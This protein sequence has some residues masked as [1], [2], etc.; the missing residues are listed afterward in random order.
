MSSV[1]VRTDANGRIL[2]KSGKTYQDLAET[3]SSPSD[4][5]SSYG[6]IATHSDSTV[7][8]SLS[9]TENGDVIAVHLVAGQTYA[10][11]YRGTPVDGIEDPYLVLYNSAGAYVTEDDD[12]GAGRGSMITYTATVTGNHYLLATS[13]YTLDT[14]NPTL[15]TGNYTLDVWA[16]NL[17]HDVPGTFAGAVSI[18][19]GT[20][21]GFLETP[22]DTDMYRIDMTA[23]MVYSFGY[24]GGISSSGDWDDEPG[25][26]IGYLELY[27]AGGNLITEAVNYET[28]LSFFAEEN[29][30]YYLRASGYDPAMTGGYTLDLAELNPAD[31]DPLESLNWDSAANVPFVNVAGT[32]TAYVYFAAAGENFGETQGDS[33]AA[34]VSLGWTNYEMQQVMLA[35]EEYEHI[36]GVDY[37]V[38]TDV[39][40]ATF[41]LITTEDEPYGAR[42]YPQDPAY[43]SAQGIGTFNVDSGGWGAFPQS[44]ERGG[45]SFAVILHEFGHA[46]GI[47]HPHDTGGGSEIMLGVT[48]STGSYGVY[49]LNQGVYTVMS[50]NDAWDFHPDGPSAFTVAGIDNGWSGSL[51][52]FDI[53]VLQARYGVHAHNTGNDVYALSDVADDAFYQTI[54]DSGGTD[55]ISYGGAL[56][57][58]ID[59]TAAT[60]DYTPTGGGVISFLYNEPGVPNSL[61][62]RG[63]YTI[64]NGVVIE[65]ASG[66]S[67]DDVL[68]GNSAANTLTGNAGHDTLLGRDGDDILNGGAGSDILNGGAGKNELIGG[69]GNDLF[70]FDDAGSKDK[71]RDFESGRDVI[72]LTAFGIDSGDVKISGGKLFVDTD[73]VGGYD[74]QIAVQGDKVKM[75]DILFSE[76]TTSFAHHSAQD[77]VIV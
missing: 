37:V 54:W 30:T 70:V 29:A 31:Y 55:A 40:Q 38:T 15:D 45:F 69:A 14:G 19:P 66:G 47:A 43:G 76:P 53:A 3:F 27:D 48:G 1:F 39:N 58:Q 49:D 26:N 62:V 57:A 10:F 59:L 42:F 18:D 50:Y 36:L 65:N 7:P 67:G 21:Y 32:P 46:H 63:G 74:L 35:L 16:A 6:P 75:S 72:D 12:G 8:G 60:L 5:A 22:G 2:A 33:D 41:R 34:L 77:Y 51:G 13:W 61:R 56:D 9:G 64:A 73:G 24:A 52:A 23:G 68:I 44:L 20:T 4:I 25:E 71:I 28:G 17:A 11:S